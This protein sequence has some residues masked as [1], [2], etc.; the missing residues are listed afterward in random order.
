MHGKGKRGPT[1]L[2]R[3]GTATQWA[4]PQDM[5]NSGEDPTLL[6]LAMKEREEVRA[7]LCS[8]LPALCA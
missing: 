3:T 7:C 1:A 6:V 5:V 8:P 2:K 4:S